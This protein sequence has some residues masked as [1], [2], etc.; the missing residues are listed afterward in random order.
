MPPPDPTPQ[1]ERQFVRVD[2]QIPF[3][4]RRISEKEL[5]EVMQHYERYRSFPKKAEGIHNLISSLD[6][7]EKLRQLERSDPILARILGQ[8][9]IKLNILL[10]LFHP[11]ESSQPFTPTPVN[12][13]GGGL[14]F[15]EKSPPIAPGDI[16]AVRMALTQDSLAAIECYTRVIR[17]LPADRAGMDKVAC[18]FEPILDADREKI[19]QHIF[20]RQSEIL[21]SQ[22]T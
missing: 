19:I 21:R 11:D 8:L 14:A 15:W 6:I 5:A 7:G 10:R 13:S 17:I 1:N 12:L 4:W 2:D 3:A 22:R 18:K 16:L 20:K 9:D